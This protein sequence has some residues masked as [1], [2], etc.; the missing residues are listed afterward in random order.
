MNL[1]C[2]VRPLHRAA[3]RPRRHRLQGLDLADDV[4]ATSPSPPRAGRAG[5]EHPSRWP[6]RHRD[7]VDRRR[8]ARARRWLRRSS[9]SSGDTDVTPDDMGTP[10]RSTFDM[11]TPCGLLR[12][13]PRR[14]SAAL[15]PKPACRRH[16]DPAGGDLPERHR[17]QVGNVVGICT[18]I[19]SHADRM[20]RLSADVTLFW[21]VG[22][23]GCGRSRST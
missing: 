5:D 20:P 7:G 18:H 3:A 13:T 23:A 17:T 19:R 1:E 4:V 2:A 21:M 11:G 9:G 10:P 16:D 12:P 15:R 8:S 6:C 22:A 14:G